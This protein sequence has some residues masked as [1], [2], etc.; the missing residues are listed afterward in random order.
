MNPLLPCLPALLLGLAPAAPSPPA[1]KSPATKPRARDLGITFGG[2]TGP[3]NA[4][5]DVPGVEVGHTTLH[6]GVGAHAVR[7]GVSAVLPRGR[8]RIAEPLFAATYNLNGNGEMTG[9]HW[10]NES[11][12]L[13][14]PLMLTTT[15]SV[16]VVRDAVVRW[17]AQRGLAWELGLPVT[18]ETYDGLLNDVNAFPVQ[19]VHALRAIDGAH[20]G[21]VAEGNVGGGTGM[22]CHGFKCGIGTASRRLEAAHGG[23]TLGVLVQANYGLRRLLTVDGAPVGR[24]ISDLQPCYAGPAAPASVPDMRPCV[25]SPKTVPERL[26]R[27]QGSIIVLVATDAPLLPHQLARLARRVPLA[28]GKMGSIGGDSS[29]DLFLAF[30]TQPTQAPQGLRVARVESLDNGAL[31]PLFEAT[32]Q[33]TQEAILN[34]LLAAETMTGN[35]SVRVFAL[36]ADRLVESVRRHAGP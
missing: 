11:G 3:L 29:G 36:P 10:V 32:V 26:N 12:L 33:A 1:P 4:I 23:Y 14:G 21:P 5:T 30:S 8:A 15:Q 24:E 35:N 18:A 27:D 7:T 19:T 9:T 31:D 6:A 16:G 13:T 22:V 20:G 28:L 17:G 34:A 2:Q 25:E